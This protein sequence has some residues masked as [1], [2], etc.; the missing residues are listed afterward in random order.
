MR[1]PIGRREV[2]RFPHHAAALDRHLAWVLDHA[3]LG[4]RRAAEESLLDLD[5]VI[6]EIVV[7]DPRAGL[8]V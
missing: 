3:A 4:E 1:R 5:A 6:A 2:A 7:D 8:R